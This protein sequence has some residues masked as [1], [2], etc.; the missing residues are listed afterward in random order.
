MSR[1]FRLFLSVYVLSG[2]VF[3]L[4]ADPARASSSACDGSETDQEL[5]QSCQES[6]PEGMSTC[7]ASCD[8]DNEG[9]VLTCVYLGPPGCSIE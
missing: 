9:C 3:L 8:C 7:S 2:G 4:S 5:M 6:A 1:R